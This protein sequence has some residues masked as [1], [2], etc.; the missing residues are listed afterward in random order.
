MP[1]PNKDN[2][3][4]NNTYKPIPNADEKLEGQ[5]DG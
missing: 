2:V 4:D 5:G 1:D 3:P